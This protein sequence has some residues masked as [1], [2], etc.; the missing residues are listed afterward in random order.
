[1]SEYREIQAIFDC[2]LSD[3]EML[4]TV[5]ANIKLHD[6]EQCQREIDINELFSIVTHS[7]AVLYLQLCKLLKGQFKI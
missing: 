3:R 1:M 6:L 5:S 4:Q 7:M 2:S